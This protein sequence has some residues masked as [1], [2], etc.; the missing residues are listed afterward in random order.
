M[1]SIVDFDPKKKEVHKWII[2]VQFD[3]GEKGKKFMEV[4]GQLIK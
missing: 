2:K 3:C 4:I 1:V